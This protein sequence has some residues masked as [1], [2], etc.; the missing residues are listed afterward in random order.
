[1]PFALPFPEIDPVLVSFEI[2]GLT[3]ALRWYALAYIAGLVFGWRYIAWMCRKPALWG[4]AP[5]MRPEQVDDLLSYAV[6]GVILGGRLGFVL[7]YQPGFYL[8]NPGE[9]LAVWR[10]GM[11]FHGGF[12]GV[13][14]AILLFAARIGAP[15]VR[16]GDAVAAA[17]PLGIA[18]GRLANFVNAELWGRPTT[19]PWGVVF[20]GEAAQTCPPGWTDICARHP[21][22]LYQ[23]GLEG[24]A[25]FLL[26]LWAVLRGRA[27]ARP[28][29]VIG[30]FLAGYGAARIFVEF[31][32]QGDGQFVTSENP[33]GLILRFGQ[34]IDSWG[35]TMGQL[36]T[37]PM[38]ALGLALILRPTRVAA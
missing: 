37:L 4:G 3:L 28:G 16:I 20:P 1:M 33:W 18:F 36:L 23:A 31:F 22:Q 10:G 21:S 7:F 2:F 17:A 5:P 25:V 13:V 32:R 29:Q 27:L 38:L 8:A 30:L 12:L 14:A 6:L 19:L 35:F 24:L 9:I 26:I 34:G 15:A 11:S